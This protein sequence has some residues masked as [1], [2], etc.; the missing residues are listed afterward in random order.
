MQ[1]SSSFSSPVILA[2]SPISRSSLFDKDRFGVSGNSGK[3]DMC[4]ELLISEQSAFSSEI[5]CLIRSCI[6]SKLL[7]FFGVESFFAEASKDLYFVFAFERKTL[8]M[9]LVTNLVGA[10]LPTFDRK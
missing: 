9:D 6:S 8:A 1:E 10:I 3:S 2:L 7:R 5:V 4:S